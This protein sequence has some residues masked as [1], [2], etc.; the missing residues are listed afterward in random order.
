[1]N[2]VFEI[3]RLNTPNR[4]AKGLAK[5]AQLGGKRDCSRVAES[6]TFDE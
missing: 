3:K 5:G 2:L 6:M 4:K 1:M